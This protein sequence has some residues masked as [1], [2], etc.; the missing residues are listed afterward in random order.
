MAGAGEPAVV[1]LDGELL[2]GLSFWWIGWYRGY[3]FRERKGQQNQ[4]LGERSPKPPLGDEARP[5]EPLRKGWGWVAVG[6]ALAGPLRW[7]AVR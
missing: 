6:G 1:Q 3:S 5:L 4:A 2:R 7:V